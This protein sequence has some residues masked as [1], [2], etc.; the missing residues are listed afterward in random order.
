METLWEKS[1]RQIAPKKSAHR[2]STF[3][4]SLDIFEDFKD[5]YTSTLDCWSDLPLGMNTF[6]KGKH[7]LT[8]ATMFSSL[9]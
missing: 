6:H 5:F 9:I 4:E 1:M 7:V 3:Y 8:T 2:L